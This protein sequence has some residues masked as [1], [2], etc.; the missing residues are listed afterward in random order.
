MSS[1]INPE[2]VSMLTSTGQ[3]DLLRL[4]LT[5]G[6]TPPPPPLP[7]TTYRNEIN[8][9]TVL[10]MPFIAPY[11]RTSESEHLILFKMFCL[12]FDE[13]PERFTIASVGHFDYDGRYYFSIKY[14]KEYNE[15]R[16]NTVFHIYGHT[17]GKKF[18]CESVDIIMG[19]A[20]YTNAVVY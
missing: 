13:H 3:Y 6:S 14:Y 15:Q 18:M 19:L 4:Y 2:V 1:S 7:P 10:R 20:K 5:T 11:K 16:V 9:D 8:W 17:K 12:E